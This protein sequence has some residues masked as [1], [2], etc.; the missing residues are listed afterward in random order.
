MT[1]HSI[2]FISLDTHK[3]FAEVADIEGQHGA[4]PIHLGKILS[5]KAALE[6]LAKY[7]N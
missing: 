6:K 1:K 4:K 7:F 5:N 3:T 2:L